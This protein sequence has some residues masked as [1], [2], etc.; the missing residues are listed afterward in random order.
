[1]T[2]NV[3]DCAG[4]NGA[5]VAKTFPLPI[6]DPVNVA[7]FLSVDGTR[8]LFTTPPVLFCNDHESA[9]IV[10]MKFPKESLVTAY[11]VMEFP[12]GT[13]WEGTIVPVP[14]EAVS[15]LKVVAIFGPT[16]KLLLVPD[17][18]PAVFVAVN[19][20]VPVL[21]NVILNEFKIPFTNGGVMKLLSII[22][23]DVIFT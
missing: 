16:E 23:F 13:F 6:R 21:E 7:L 14:S 19:T 10:P 9:A 11:M 18:V 8:L 5:T 4:E 15:T 22:P 3:P 2:V 12:D 17:C 1:M 20:N